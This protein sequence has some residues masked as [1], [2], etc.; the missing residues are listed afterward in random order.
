MLI[1]GVGFPMPHGLMATSD[2]A[3]G[4]LAMCLLEKLS[5]RL[6]GFHSTLVV[7]RY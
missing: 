7:I 3:I 2:Q 1:A 5:P 6:A 4:W